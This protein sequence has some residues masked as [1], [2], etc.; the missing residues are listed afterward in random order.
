[1]PTLSQFIVWVIIGL[2]GGTL[3]GRLIAWDRGGFGHFRNL[4]LGLAGALVGGFAFRVLGLF[5]GLDSIAISAR[6]IVAA[7]AGSL[8]IVAVVWIFQAARKP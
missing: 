4:G 2:L 8:T 6:D 1:M 5:P 3:A 7:V